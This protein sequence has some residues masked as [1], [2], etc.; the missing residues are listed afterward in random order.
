MCHTC[1]MPQERVRITTHVGKTARTCGSLPHVRE[2]VRSVELHARTYAGK[3]TDHTSS[4]AH[5]HLPHERG[6]LNPTSPFGQPTT[7]PVRFTAHH[8]PQQTAQTILLP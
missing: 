5:V 3:A 6:P 7:Q 2:H 1:D 4:T 8:V